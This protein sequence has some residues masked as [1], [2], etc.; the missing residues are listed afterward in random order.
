MKF[1]TTSLACASVALISVIAACSNDEDKCTVDT[2]YNPLIDPAGFASSTV[3]DNQL[4][5]LVPGTTYTYQG[6]E[7]TITV[8]IT[9]E[10]KTILGVTCVVVRD[11]V[12]VGGQTTEDTFDWYAQDNDGNVWYFGEDT[13]EYEN[14]TVVSTEGSWEAGVDGAK[15]G[16][17][18]HAIQP[19]AAAP[20]RQEYYA[21]EAED[22][23]EVVSLNEAVTVPFGQYTNCLK[24]HEFTPLEPDASEYKY[25][26]ENVGLVLEEDAASGARTELTQV[27]WL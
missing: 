9:S 6:G 11:T 12:R 25:Y 14:G 4:M 27:I 26:C 18:M 20:Y 5:P 17:V 22:M 19:A 7:E 2:T 16:I 13:K 3:I 1:K 23:A 15:P 24:T 21:C 8:A 10:T